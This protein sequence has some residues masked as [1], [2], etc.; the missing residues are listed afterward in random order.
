[1]AGPE[2]ALGAREHGIRGG[3]GMSAGAD[4][5]RTPSGLALLLALAALFLVASGVNYYLLQSRS[6]AAAH[7]LPVHALYSL[8]LDAAGAV[9]GETDALTRFQQSQKTL[10]DAAARDAR[11]PFASDARFTRL[12]NNAA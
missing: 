8:A 7:A 6:A 9:A 2:P 4:S 11:A 12:L 1:M 10:E 3:C 5:A